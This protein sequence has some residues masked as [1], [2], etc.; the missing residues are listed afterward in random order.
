MQAEPTPDGYRVWGSSRSWLVEHYTLGQ[1]TWQSEWFTYK[2]QA[3]A[4]M[5]R[6]R[7]G[8]V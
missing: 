5:R 8:K 3:E 4:E 2:E 7:G 1:L 6:L